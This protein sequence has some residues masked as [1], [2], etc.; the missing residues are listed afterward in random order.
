MSIWEHTN[1]VPPLAWLR[2][3]AFV[4]SCTF[5]NEPL[6]L[7]RSDRPR[8]NYLGDTHVLRKIN[9]CRV[10]GW[11]KVLETI[12]SYVE[13]DDPYDADTIS[14]QAAV[15]V[16]KQFE[17]DELTP[18]LNEVR[19]FLAGRPEKRFEISPQRIEKIVASVFRSC[20]CYVEETQYSKDGGIDAVVYGLDGVPMPIQVKAPRSNKRVQVGAIREFLGAMLVDGNKKGI[21]YTR[22]AFVTMSEYTYG[23]KDAAEYCGIELAL[24]DA[25]RFFDA[26]RIA[27]RADYKARD[28]DALNDNAQLTHV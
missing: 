19:A 17:V 9:V 5:C 12:H 10:C 21:Q 11:W 27:Q 3:V 28:V 7:V 1:D 13:S 2:E 23:A 15:G 26:L 14:Y 18:A 6:D 16:L 4:T 22:G 20:G 8:R 25:A 24:Y